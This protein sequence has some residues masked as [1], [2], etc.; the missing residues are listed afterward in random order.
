MDQHT[1]RLLL[2]ELAES[3]DLKEPQS[4]LE[5]GWLKVDAREVLLH[6]DEDID[7]DHLEIR[8]CVGPEGAASP[9]P[10][11]MN[12]A[13][14]ANYMSSEPNRTVF[15]MHPLNNRLVLTLRR[16]ISRLQGGR[17]LLALLRHASEQLEKTWG[18]LG[19]ILDKQ[20]QQRV[21]ALGAHRVA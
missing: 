2:E 3:L 1:Y 7:A 11:L 21:P 16:N 5:E 14:M 12:A 8:I 15:S 20:Q 18:Q 9:G 17:D 13:L 19:S 4:L 6:Y 10:D